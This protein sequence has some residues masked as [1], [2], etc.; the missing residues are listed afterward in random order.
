MKFE[1]GFARLVYWKLF[2]VESLFLWAVEHL[3]SKMSRRGKVCE[4]K[5]YRGS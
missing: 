4:R 5:L 2:G 3:K 1:G